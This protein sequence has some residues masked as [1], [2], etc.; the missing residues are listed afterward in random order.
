ML[1]YP[2][3]GLDIERFLSDDDH[4]RVVMLDK[5]EL[6]ERYINY[7]NVRLEVM[8]VYVERFVHHRYDRRL[9]WYCPGGRHL[10]YFYGKDM[11]K[12]S[13]TC[14]E[15]KFA[16]EATHLALIGY[17]HSDMYQI[18]TASMLF[19]NVNTVYHNK[20]VP[21]DGENAL[22]RYGEGAYVGCPLYNE[23]IKSMPQ[24]RFINLRG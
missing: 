3:A 23:W 19:P 7:L 9:D 18:T 16:Q 4:L 14:E 5:M 24:A 22:D 11:Y 1:F 10:T 20:W 21:K 8:G 2:A 6:T 17:Y 13:P 12:L 15:Y